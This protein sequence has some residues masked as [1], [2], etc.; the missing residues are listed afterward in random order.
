MTIWN[1]PMPDPNYDANQAARSAVFA[2]ISPAGNW[3]NPIDCWIAASELAD[4]EAACV[5][6][7]GS[8]LRVVAR[9]GGRC[10]VKAA[11]Y[12]AAVG[13]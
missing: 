6:F 9:K 13:A 4:C 12:Y 8:K 3:K 5:F 10:R 2:K 1:A 11:G 7:T